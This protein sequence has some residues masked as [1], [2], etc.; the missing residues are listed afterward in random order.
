MK[1]ITLCLVAVSAVVLLVNEVS[2]ATI[3]D[4]EAQAQKQEAK[5]EDEIYEKTKNKFSGSKKH[6]RSADS[7]E[8]DEEKSPFSSIGKAFDYV[9][10]GVKGAYHNVTNSDAAAKVSESFGKFKDSVKETGKKEKAAVH[11]YT[12]P[13]ADQDLTDQVQQKV[14]EIVKTT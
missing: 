2:S 7:S 4:L 3:Y 6:R 5:Y 9:K 13:S 10:D 11:E 14:Q 8:E 1:S 12:A